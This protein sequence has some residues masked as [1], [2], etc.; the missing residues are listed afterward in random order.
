MCGNGGVVVWHRAH[1]GLPT[2]AASVA[3]PRCSGSMAN[4]PFRKKLRKS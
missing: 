4:N 3:S 2:R 1:V